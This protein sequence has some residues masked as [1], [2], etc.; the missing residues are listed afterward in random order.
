MGHLDAAMRKLLH[1]T[2]AEALQ[3]DA[4]ANRRRTVRIVVKPAHIPVMVRQR[5]YLWL[6]LI[7]AV[8][9]VGQRKVL[10]RIGRPLA[11]R[12]GRERERKHHDKGTTR[13]VFHQFP[14]PGNQPASTGQIT[15]Y[16]SN[17]AVNPHLGVRIGE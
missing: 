4:I 10:R 14:P 6:D 8:V 11:P 5:L 2:G 7:G 1:S 12:A 16:S 9:V 17:W 3:I 15:L 13:L